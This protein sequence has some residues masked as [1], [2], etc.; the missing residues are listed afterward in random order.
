MQKRTKMHPAAHGCPHWS[1]H[2]GSQPDSDRDPE[3]GCR[4]K[5][6]GPYQNAG[7][8]TAPAFEFIVHGSSSELL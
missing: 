4:D 8:G 2:P 7:H 3:N 6:A 1:V 5:D